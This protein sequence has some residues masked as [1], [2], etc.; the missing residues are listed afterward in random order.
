[1]PAWTNT[2]D[3][4]TRLGGAT[5]SAAETAVLGGM[6]DAAEQSVVTFLGYDPSVGGTATEF[7]TGDATPV[8]QLGPDVVSVTN[9]WVDW[10]GNYGVPSGSFDATATLLTAGDDYVLENEGG[11]VTGR[12]LRLGGAV[13][14]YTTTREVGRLAPELSPNRGSVKVTLVR[15]VGPNAAVVEATYALAAALWSARV[16]GMGSLNS[17]SLDGASY[18]VSPFAI[19]GDGS[20]QLFSPV[21]ELMLRPFKRRVVA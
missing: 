2:T 20:P 7:F 10:V 8:L 12:L 3:V 14:P 13:W 18:S 21:A 11:R 1:M 5:P 9:V 6:L 17:E 19:A 4:A 15:R 16:N